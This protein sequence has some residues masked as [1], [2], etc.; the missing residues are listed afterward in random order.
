M[1]I[2]EVHFSSVGIA[3]AAAAAAADLTGKTR[4]QP[5]CPE[6]RPT[7]TPG[8]VLHCPSLN[9]GKIRKDV[10]TGNI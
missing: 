9:E 1:D 7:G 2:P 10:R 6:F 8:K 5:K 4:P 3:V